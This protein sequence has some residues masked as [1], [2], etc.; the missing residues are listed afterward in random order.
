MRS[1]RKAWVLGIPSIVLL[2][3]AVQAAA[4]EKPSV[5][6]CD[7]RYLDRNVVFTVE[8]QSPNPVTLI[9][10]HIGNSRKDVKVDEY[11]NR[12]N[13]AGYS[14]ESTIEIALSPDQARDGAPYIVQIED[15]VRQKSEQVTG[16]VRLP[17]AA[18]Q[19]S[20]DNW[21]R[22]HL[23]KFANPP[24]IG[25][26][27]TSSTPYS[28]VDPV[29]GQ[30]QVTAGSYPQNPQDQTGYTAANAGAAGFCVENIIYE[31]LGD[32]VNVTVTV[33]DPSGTGVDSINLT[34]IDA[35]LAPIQA[36]PDRITQ[37]DFI[38]GKFV[39]KT[40]LRLPGGTYYVRG[41]AVNRTGQPS[42][43]MTSAP[44]TV[45]TTQSSGAST[46]TPGT[47]A[48]ER[49]GTA[50]AGNMLTVTVSVLDNSG[51]PPAKVDLQLAN[52]NRMLIDEIPVVISQFTPSSSSRPA[53]FE[54][55]LGPVQ[56]DNGTYFVKG[57]A[58]SAANQPSADAWS[59]R[60]E[61][62]GTAPAAGQ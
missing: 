2:A 16:K 35:N 59:D 23:D 7:A 54:A 24:P 39:G 14:G 19:E 31:N 26:P 43:E 8:W 50:V 15:D 5:T 44:L 22:T 37:I 30:P 21:G 55:V 32:A 9:R 12:R 51:T 6:R 62:P 33:V 49:I 48:I 34:I 42:S 60:F 61:I 45:G 52:A 38:N 3:A 46:G 1:L 53:V 28:A 11:D 56:L 27:N 57:V 17:A 25:A 47:A 36:Q 29:T 40:T 4:G 20:G 58:Y 13:Q 18:K 41:V 10:V